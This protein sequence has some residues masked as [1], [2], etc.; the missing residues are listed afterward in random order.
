MAGG[1]G[2]HTYWGFYARGGERGVSVVNSIRGG[3]ERL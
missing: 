3:R 2:L 1:E